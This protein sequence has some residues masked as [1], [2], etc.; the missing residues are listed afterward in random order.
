MDQER[1]PPE[2]EQR[3]LPEFIYIETENHEEQG[4]RGYQEEFRASFDKMEG[5]NYPFSVRL[6]CLI[7]ALFL[8]FAVLLTTP[9]LLVF[10]LINL[11]TVFQLTAF[12]ERTKQ[13]WNAYRKLFVTLL[14]LFVAVFSP[15]FGLS[16]IMMY[17]MMRGQQSDQQW[18]SRIM[19]ARF[20][21]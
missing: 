13:L 3:E 14:G 21:R 1:W 17:F 20:R 2:N 18:V 19:E 9:F 8:L 11:V 12:W 7:S 6:V 10:F 16:I 4:S 15:A 5:R